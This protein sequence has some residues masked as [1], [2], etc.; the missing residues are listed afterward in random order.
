MVEK[1]KLKKITIGLLAAVLVGIAIFLIAF[2]VRVN[3]S[4][5]F[6]KQQNFVASK[7]LELGDYEQGKILALQTEQTKE[8][9]TSKQ[10]VV[11]A[12]GFQGEYDLAISY[13]E[14]YL[15]KEED[16]ILSTTKSIVE[17][18]IELE[19]NS[20]AVSYVEGYEQQKNKIRE[21][22]L[23]V[24]LQIQN[25][26]DVKKNSA[27]IQ[28]MVDMMSSGNLYLNEAVLAEL[29]KDDSMLSNKVQAVYA[30]YT[31]D[32]TKALDK[33]E[34]VFELDKSF[35]NRAMLANIV[36]VM[37]MSY[38]QSGERITELRK[39]LTE[40]NSE[41][42]ELKSLHAT[43]SSETEKLKI[44]KKMDSLNGEMEKLQNTIQTEPVRRAINFIE[45]TTPIRERDTIAYKLELSQLYYKA[46]E[47]E[48][49]KE[50]LVDVI[51]KGEG[52]DP[53]AMLVKDWIEV[54]QM[55]NGQLDK[56]SYSEMENSNLNLETYWNRI[57]E[58][59]HFIERD[60]YYG[61]NNGSN[62]YQFVVEI[63][64]KLYNGL[65][66]REIDATD[67]PVVRVTVNV[68]M[69]LEERLTKNNFKLV[70]MNDSIKN[71]K[72]L[73][74]EQMEEE[75]EISLMLV[76]DRSGSMSGQPMQ[77][78]KKAVASFV[79]NAQEDMKIGLVAFDNIAEVVTPLSNNRTLLLKGVNSIV[80]GGGTSIYLGLQTAGQELQKESGKKVI[81]LLSDGEDGDSSQ[82]DG[83][84][85]EL[86]RKNIYVYTIA[87]GGADTE[88]LSYIA[89]SCRGKFI[90]ADSS[91][92]LGEVY[93]SIGNYMV[94]D[95]VIEFTA[96]TEP[97]EFERVVNVS[98]DMDDAFVEKEYCVGVPYEDIQKEME[99]PLANYFWQV[100][101]SFIEDSE[102]NDSND[103]WI[104]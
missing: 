87:F 29:E 45:T 80:D 61:Y 77:D 53:I 2:F 73:T 65:I 74:E 24:L 42:N 5:T 102:E 19:S 67:F 100:G 40:L 33:A 83:V 86:K 25:S 96:K 52:K 57:A 22:M 6:I 63:L 69:E 10:L 4:N 16:E 12:S 90:H 71:F 59:L 43:A 60:Y 13:A 81:I 88:Y 14:E 1:K 37:D 91:E 56:S 68:A 32:Y 34:K 92:V 78:T 58:L 49:A 38:E 82:I 98:I 55:Q 20:I 50:L 75:E 72:I 103:E 36:S 23:G 35:E 97:K 89:N 9:I 76:V 66:I 27:S 48:K 17:E 28:A 64:N 3:K 94:N 62:F 85:A 93:S 101:G 39:D 21:Q 11:L 46:K 15:K 79:R 95:Y 30:I 70:E 54:Y 8:N 44:T 104:E 18:L 41:M 51:K 47:E 7:L 84:L 99:A 31:G 26:I